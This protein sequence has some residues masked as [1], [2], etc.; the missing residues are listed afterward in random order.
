MELMILTLLSGLVG[1]VIGSMVIIVH[2]E[3][4]D[5]RSRRLSLARAKLEKVYGP[6]VALKKKIDEVNQDNHGIIRPSNP[7]EKEMIEKIIFHYYHLVDDDLKEGMVLLHPDINRGTT[8]VFKIVQLKV[9]DKIMKH[10]SENRKVL[11]L[12]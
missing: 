10:Y 7:M 5:W 12:K 8:G 1:A 6:L 9:M 4:R 2:T 11:G 3:Y